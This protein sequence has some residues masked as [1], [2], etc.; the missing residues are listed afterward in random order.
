MMARFI[1]HHDGG[2][3]VWSTIVD[4]PL[5]D[6]AL[7]LAQLRD[8]EPVTDER[9]ARAHD[10]GCSALSGET[11]DGCIAVNRAGPDETQLSRDEFIGR[12]LIVSAEPTAHLAARTP[13]GGAHD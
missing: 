8:A 4:A 13:I 10:K 7:T 6:S 11:L 1:L 3:N 12:F 9:L 2:Y 5:Y